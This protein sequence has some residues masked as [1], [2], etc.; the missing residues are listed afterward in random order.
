[1]K[2]CYDL[3]VVDEVHTTLSPKYRNMY[4]NWE[5]SQIM[6]LTATLPE[7]TEYR[8]FL[9]TVAPVVYSKSFKDIENL[10][11]VADYQIYNLPVTFTTADRAKYNIFNKNFL[12]AQMQVAILKRKIAS[13]KDKSVFDVAKEWYLK[14][15]PLESDPDLKLLIKYSKQFWSSMTMRKWVCYNSVAKVKMVERIIEHFPDKK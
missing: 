1:M 10:E 15:I 8:M 14:K 13:L 11:V 5:Y 7:D 12:E 4:A 2:K 3:I 6:C 9:D